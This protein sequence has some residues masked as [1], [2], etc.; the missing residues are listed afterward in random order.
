MRKVRVTGKGPDARL[1]LLIAHRE[2]FANR[3]ESGKKA[4]VSDSA[5]REDHHEGECSS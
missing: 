1:N 2:A 3:Q 4:Y 5:C